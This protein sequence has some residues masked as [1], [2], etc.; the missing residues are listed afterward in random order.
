MVEETNLFRWATSEL[1]QD[2]FICWLLSWADRGNASKNL[3]NHQAGLTFLNVLMQVSGQTAVSS[4]TVVVHKQ[5]ASTDIV[6]EV[7]ADRVLLIED[8]TNASE[9]GDQLDRYIVAIQAH[10]PKCT[11]LPIFCKTGDQSGY[12]KARAAGY[13]LFLRQD[14]LR[15][16][17]EIKVSMPYNNIFNDFLALLESREKA[18]QSYL[19][20]HIGEWSNFAWQG[21]FLNLQEALPG[22]EWGYVANARGGFMG[23]WWHFDMWSNWQTYL[24]IEENVLVMKMACWETIYPAPV[25]AAIRNRWF[26]AL[27]V[28]GIGSH[29]EVRRPAR[30]GNG[31]SMTAAHIGTGNSWLQRGEDGRLDFEATVDFLREAMVVLDR[32]RADC[33]VT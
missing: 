8:K 33:T 25:R 2:A 32:A 4:E 27:L 29:I 17:Q 22:V 31:A 13:A 12:N 7:G 28:A 11:I 21:F 9:H 1:S 24:Q 5:L 14:F 19:H 16:L 20:I 23:A 10:F 6:A 18:T 30:R 3:A 26:E 15:V